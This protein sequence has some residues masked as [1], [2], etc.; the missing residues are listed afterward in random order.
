MSNIFMTQTLANLYSDQGK[1]EKSADIYKA[2]IKELPEN[3]E[4]K[5]KLAEIESKIIPAKEQSPENNLDTLETTDKKNI[6]QNIPEP[7]SEPLESEVLEPE[8]PGPE[9]SEPE[10]SEP[11][12]SE[13]EISEPEISEPEAL[14]TLTSEVSEPEEETIKKAPLTK[15]LVPL[16]S[17]WLD[18]M[19]IKQLEA[20]RA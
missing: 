12:I 15:R 5:E 19:H 7:E 13:P 4:L 3:Q 17:E 14:E 2:L 9:I 11:E 10:I 6:E 20:V 16:I 18:L 1:Y 8:I